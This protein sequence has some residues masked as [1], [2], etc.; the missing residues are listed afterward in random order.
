M[1]RITV[2]NP[3]KNKTVLFLEGKVCQ[4]WVKELQAEIEKGIKEGKKVILDF[5][6]VNYLDEKA[7]K[8]INRLPP[9]K[10]EKRNCSLFIRT[11]LGM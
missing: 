3:S 5:S 11:M 6:K 7:V 2:K 1:L 4:E 9:K 8:M 10:I